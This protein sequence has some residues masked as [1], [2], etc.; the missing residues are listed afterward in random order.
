MA[1][2]CLGGLNWMNERNLLLDGTDTLEVVKCLSCPIR[3]RMLNLLATQMMSISD[4]AN[5]LGVSLPSAGI[6]VKQLRE[7]GLIH[8]HVQRG[9][10]GA[11]KICSRLYDTITIKLPGL[12]VNP[13]TESVS[14][15]MPIGNYKEIEVEPT[16]GIVSESGFIGLCDD[17][18]AFYEPEHVFAQLLW[19][20]KGT[21]TYMFPNHLP[22]HTTMDRLELSMEICSE[23]PNYNEDWPS[24]ITLWIN[25]REVGTWTSPGDMGGKQGQLTPSWWLDRYTQHGFLKTWTVTNEGS[26]ID[27]VQISDVTLSKLGIEPSEPVIAV[28]IGNKPNCQH[29]RGFNLFG[30]KFGNYPQDIV[31][32]MHYAKEYEQRNSN[33]VNL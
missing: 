9:K 16:C 24:D 14:V 13:G 5:E 32:T 22:L 28:K 15:T 4:L 30:R 7:A 11:Q 25:D 8:V 3:L 21:V 26:F 23:A 19:V 33:R 29:P 31:L 18:K 1:A 2:G 10:R 12:E 6:K 20:G 17:P 27:G